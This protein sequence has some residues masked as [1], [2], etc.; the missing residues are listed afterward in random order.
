MK[1]YKLQFQDSGSGTF[2]PPPPPPPPSFNQPPPPSFNQGPPPPPPSGQFYGGVP[3]K[4]S[5]FA[6]TALI[7]GIVSFLTGWCCG[8]PLAIVALIFAIL[9]LSNIKKG[10]ASDRGKGMDIAALILSGI[11]IVIWLILLIIGSISSLI[12]SYR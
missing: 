2:P 12:E 11:T 9:D 5:G 4:A 10:K 7:L 8:G 1:T 6:I 3:D